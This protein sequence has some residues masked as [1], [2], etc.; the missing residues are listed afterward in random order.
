MP[1]LVLKPLQAIP[2]CVVWLSYKS[3]IVELVF[4]FVFF[5]GI[6]T[7]EDIQ[8]IGCVKTIYMLCQSYVWVGSC[9]HMVCS[10]LLGL[11]HSS[12]LIIGRVGCIVGVKTH[13]ALRSKYFA[14]FLL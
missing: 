1:V 6:A 12:F 7:P 8:H 11:L 9:V 2:H 5:R 10:R 3:S 13:S 14:V 4:F